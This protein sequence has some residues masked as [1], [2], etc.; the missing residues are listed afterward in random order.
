MLTDLILYLLI[1]SFTGVLAGLFGVGGGTII[2]PALILTLT[3]QGVSTIVLTHI[4]IG[5]SLAAISV[6]S[7]SSIQAHHQRNAVLWPVARQLVPGVCVGVWAGAAIASHLS[8]AVLQKSF[9]VFLVLIAM[10][11]GLN[12]QPR[13]QAETAVLPKL[14]LLWITG[15]VIGLLSAVFGIGGGSLTV[16][17][18]SWHGVRMQNAVATAAAAGFP[19]AVVGACA[20][21]W[22]G[23]GNA[24]LP[25]ASSGFVYWPAFAGIAVTSIGFAKLGAQ[26]A[27]MLDAQKLKRLFALFLFA[28]GIYFL[29][30]R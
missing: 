24:L 12:L 21:I 29:I 11:M 5:T 22:H 28:L 9:G 20:Y 2:V 18:L 4:A 8:G 10:Q 25:A 27:H 15:T 30:R 19:I 1:G 13:L 16:P 23:W 3:A 26:M 7:I 6:T 14:G 17:F